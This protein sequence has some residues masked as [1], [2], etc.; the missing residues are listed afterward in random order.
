MKA[1][2]RLISEND[3]DPSDVNAIYIT[4]AMDKISD[5]L[6]NF[7]DQMRKDDN[8]TSEKFREIILSVA[9]TLMI[10]VLGKVCYRTVPPSQHEKFIDMIVKEIK[11]S[12]F[13]MMKKET[14]DDCC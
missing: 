5:V 6:D 2:H 7:T 13:E 1:E 8:V 4:K 14:A 11:P 9:T 10:R 3:I 12:V